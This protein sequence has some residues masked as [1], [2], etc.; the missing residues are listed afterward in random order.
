MLVLAVIA[1]WFFRGANRGWTKD[2]VPHKEIDPVTELE[3]SREAPK[4]VP[5]VDF[6]AGGF[7]AAGFLWGVS[8]FF[9]R[10]T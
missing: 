9:R 10:R 7:A 1:V 5:G 6:L 8:F 4:W 2:F 3:V